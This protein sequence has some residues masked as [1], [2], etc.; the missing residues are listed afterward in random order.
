MKHSSRTQTADPRIGSLAVSGL[1]GSRQGRQAWLRS[2]RSAAPRVFG[3]GLTLFDPR[4]PPKRARRRRGV[5]TLEFLLAFPIVFITTLAI[6]QFGILLVVQQAV[7]GAA[8]DGAREAAK[9]GATLDCVAA[10][11]QQYLSVHCITFDPTGT[12]TTDEAHLLV[13]DGSGM[14][15]G[16]RGNTDLACS[17][18]GPGPSG[19]QVRVT[20]CVRVTDAAGCHPVPNWLT[21]FG[22]SQ[23]DC[24]F[25]ISSLANL[26]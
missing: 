6:F 19:S 4:H 11:V 1:P 15:S 21:S 8:V 23:E 22:F 2:Q 26:E 14:T 18:H 25:E 20:V 9:V 10:C 17:P 12:N 24:V 13:E 7:T 16:E 3:W 5:I